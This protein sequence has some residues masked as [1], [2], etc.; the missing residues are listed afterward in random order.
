[1]PITV[2]P[3]TLS[4]I[5]TPFDPRTNSDGFASKVMPLLASFLSESTA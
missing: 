2:F 1:M 4:T 5:E 3:V